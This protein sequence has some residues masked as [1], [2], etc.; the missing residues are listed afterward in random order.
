M[1]DPSKRPARA[2]FQ[3]HLWTGIGIALYLIVVSLTGALLVF[4]WEIEAW[5]APR[6]AAASGPA[7]GY[8]A[9]RDA[10]V[11]AYP[12]AHVEGFLAPPTPTSAVQVWLEHREALVALRFDVLREA[13]HEI[14][15]RRGDLEEIGI[16][17]N[18]E[19]VGRAA[20]NDRGLELGGQRLHRHGRAR[21]N[22]QVDHLDVRIAGQ[23]TEGSE[24]ARA[25]ETGRR[26]N[27]TPS[28]TVAARPARVTCPPT[29]NDRGS[30][31]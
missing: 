24:G 2:L 17:R 16:G 13:R 15:R 5:L 25:D 4:H 30:Y 6:P 7:L 19:R 12:G 20:G 21:R 18:A 11:R 3:V 10:V 1:T 23:A 31:V 14:A 22:E 8:D 29:R 27:A 9:L 28:N 26:R